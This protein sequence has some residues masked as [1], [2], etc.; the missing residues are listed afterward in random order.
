MNA[1]TRSKSRRRR[2]RAKLFPFLKWARYVN[3]QSLRADFL[4]GMTGAVIVL[5]QG[6]AFAL[7]AGLPPQYGLYTAI[8]TT[9]I[10]ALF[11]SSR[12]MVTGPT[13]AISLV[14]LGVVGGFAAPGGPDYLPYV[15]TLT[16]LVGVFQFLLGLIRMGGLVNFISHTVVIGFTA[17]AAVLIA[18]NQ[19]EH[20]FGVDVPNAES[21]Y[22]SL[23]EFSKQ[24]GQSNPYVILVATITLVSAVLIRFFRPRW[25]AML[26]GIVA[27]SLACLL[28]DGPG[29]G[30][31]LL[32]S[33]PGHLPPP[34]IPDFSIGTVQELAPGALAL[35]MIGLI[36]AVS[37]A[38]SIATRSH[39]RIDGNQEFI[40]QGL[41]NIVGS[42]F[43]CYA[44]S[45]SFTRSGINFEAGAQTPLSAIFASLIVALILR[46]LGPLT[47]C[48]QRRR[49]PP[50]SI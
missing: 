27:G 32:G 28:M 34:S 39:Q 19:F 45:G 4:A 37:I 5:P 33:L 15:L 38:R 12:H 36:E 17:G 23:T 10:A 49:L 8:V 21:F 46:F 7:I 3:P 31:P 1:A 20:F 44:G 41:A 42:F 2:A 40:G 35:A 50:G 16:F 29:H 25:P 18:V 30:V 14:V 48:Q 9:V 26:I 22:Q 13:T 11:G 24:I 43:S 6:V 47:A